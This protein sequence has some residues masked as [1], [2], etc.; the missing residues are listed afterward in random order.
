[1]GATPRE[2]R[3]P[4][5]PPTPEGRPAGQPARPRRDRE[6]STRRGVEQ[7]QLVGLITQRSGVRIPPPLPDAKAGTE[8]CRRSCFLQPITVL[9]L[10]EHPYTRLCFGGII[11]VFRHAA[12]FV[13]DFV[14]PKR[15]AGCSRRGT[16]LCDDCR[17]ELPCFTSPWCDR[18]GVPGTYSRCKCP[19][20]PGN[21]EQ[22]RSVG[23]FDGWLRGA[24]VQFKYYGEWARAAHLGEPLATAVAHL[25]EI[26]VLVPVPL[27]SARLRQRGFNQSLLLAQHAGS[28]L[29][30]EIVEALVRTRRTSA[31]VN[32]GAE[33]RLANVAGAFAVQ[34]N[35]EVAG[36]SV[37]LI[38]DVVT[39][40][41]TLSACAEAL[42]RAG[43]AS[44]R[45]ACLAREM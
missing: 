25:Q 14:Y 35:V 36:L 39:T 29:G 18:C 45:A 38:D 3:P 2:A 43:A 31:Q 26:D 37:V 16:W 32:L 17:M 12:D 22:V 41:S 4:R 7:R 10:R 15:C 23:P 34:P 44:V 5:A 8:R 21:L 27:H 9:Q 42:L 28:L 24:V 11:T 6:P 20:T 13:I 19:S 30:I 33:Q 40:G 1:M